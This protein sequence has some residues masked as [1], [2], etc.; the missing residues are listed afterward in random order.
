MSC[1]D[2]KN[3]KQSRQEDLCE[4]MDASVRP[5]GVFMV[6]LLMKERCDMPSK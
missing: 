4:N 1:A 6:Q 3:P 2:K 5:G